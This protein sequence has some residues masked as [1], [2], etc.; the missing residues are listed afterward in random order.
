M[1]P[2]PTL[3]VVDCRKAAL[4]PQDQIIKFPDTSLLI[5]CSDLRL[6]HSFSIRMCKLENRSALFEFKIYQI[7]CYFPC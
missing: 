5:P 2:S 3:L 1:K 6:L 7:R 4:H